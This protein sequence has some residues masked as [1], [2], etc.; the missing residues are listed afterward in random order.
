MNHRLRTHRLAAVVVLVAILSFFPASATPAEVQMR[1][2]AAEP[3]RICPIDW[4]RSTWHVRKL[5]RCAAEHH[6]LSPRRSLYVAY[7]ESRYFP[8][9]YNE[10]SCAKG[11]FQHLCRY[12]AS[13]AEAFGFP[14]RSAFNARANIFV[15]MRM[16]KRSGWGP[17]GY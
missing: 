2:G 10:T 7:R 3:T 5:I 12:W 13:R 14:E 9:A 1:Y 16:V 8:R 6:G 11:I 15:T 17:W 4:R